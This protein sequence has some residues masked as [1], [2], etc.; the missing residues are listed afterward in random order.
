MRNMV[1]QGQISGSRETTVLSGCSSA[2]RLTRWISVRCRGRSRRRGPDRRMMKSVEPTSS[3]SSTTSW[4]HS[5]CTTTIP[6]GA[7]RGTPRVGGPEPLMDRA[8]SLPQQERGRLDPHV[9]E[10][11]SS[12]RG[13]TPPCPRRRSRVERGVAPEC[14]SGRTGPCRRVPCPGA[15]DRAPTSAPLAHSKRCTP[16]AV[17]SDERLQRRRRVHVGDRTIRPVSVTSPSAA[18]ASS[19]A[20]MSAMSAIEQP[21]FRSGAA[22]AGGLGEDVGRFGHEVHA[23]KDDEVGLRAVCRD[24]RQAERVAAHIGPGHDLVTL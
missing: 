3:A 16:P 20:S 14:W 9:V 18:H 24:A 23:A 21:A 19:T 12:R 4:A 6:S 10:T 17:A 13:S 22:P 15:R 2:S 1:E 7:R 8:M 11:P 5:G